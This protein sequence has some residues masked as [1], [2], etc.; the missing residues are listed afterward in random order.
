VLVVCAAAASTSIFLIL[1]MDEPFSGLLK[2]SNAPL[3]YALAH[4]GQ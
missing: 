2:V 4:M 3:R 1:E